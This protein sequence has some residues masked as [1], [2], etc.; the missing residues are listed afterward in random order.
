MCNEYFHPRSIRSN[1]TLA[2]FML[3]IWKGMPHQ[4]TDIDFPK[5]IVRTSK[6]HHLKLPQRKKQH[7]PTHSVFR[8]STWFYFA[9]GN[10]NLIIY[11]WLFQNNSCCESGT[12]V[13]FEQKKHLYLM[14]AF[15][16]D[17]V[18]TNHNN[19][20]PNKTPFLLLTLLILLSS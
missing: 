8:E 12:V 7:K 16:M 1:K 15:H 20:L 11:G 17:M 4:C 19:P 3:E 13:L 2:A 10:C 14:V 9:N 18:Q 6:P 5:K